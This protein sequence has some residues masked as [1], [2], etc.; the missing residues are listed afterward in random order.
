[1]N[2]QHLDPKLEPDLD[3]NLEP[4][5]PSGLTSG[6][7][8]ILKHFD[9]NTGQLEGQ[10]RLERH[11]SDLEGIYSDA[12]AYQKTLALGNPVVYSVSSLEPGHGAGDLH[13][14]LGVI[15]PG[16]VG[17]EFF[18]TKGHLHEW[19]EA[20]EVYIGLS[21]AGL[22][23]LE[24]ESGGEVRA[25]PFGA[26]SIV[27]VPGFTAH[28]TVN[29][30]T[31]PLKYIGVYPARAGHD[32]ATIRER[33]FAQVVIAAPDGYRVLERSEFHKQS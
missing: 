14:G 21:G 11:L 19:R 28:R 23:L 15:Q 3:A 18:M 1:V 29:V 33:N 26:N 4:T 12:Q 25:V 9:L 31:E 10:P 2:D 16:R 27:Y 6:L 8:N 24:H 20:A 32:Y 13:Y 17:Q 30:G 7:T 22:M 5:P